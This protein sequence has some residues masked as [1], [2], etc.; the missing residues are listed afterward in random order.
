MILIVCILVA[1]VAYDVGMQTFEPGPYPPPGTEISL[2]HSTQ[3]VVETFTATGYGSDSPWASPEMNVL[4]MLLDITG[5]GLFFLAL[6]AV[7]LPLFQDAL[8]P[9]APTELDAQIDGHVVVC[10]DTSRA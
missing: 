4:V 1:A 10:S 8:S 9:S 2:L 5:V 3:V 6:P 7:L